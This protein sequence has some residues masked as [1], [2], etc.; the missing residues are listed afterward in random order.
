MFQSFS[1]FGQF[2]GIGGM[3]QHQLSPVPQQQFLPKSRQAPCQPAA[4]SAPAVVPVVTPIVVIVN[5]TFVFE[6]VAPLASWVIDY[7][8]IN[9]F[10]SVTVTD[11]AGNVVGANVRY[12]VG[13]DRVIVTFA[14]P[15]AGS[16]Y[17]NV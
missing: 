11:T 2:Q 13:L 7:P 3:M 16:A 14:D 6:Q 9:Q 8:F 15:F 12:I 10:P 4:A 17:L 1:P 5:G